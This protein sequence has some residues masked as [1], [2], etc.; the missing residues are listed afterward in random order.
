[1]DAQAQDR[2]HRIG[3]TREVH[4]KIA[5]YVWKSMCALSFGLQ[6]VFAVYRL[7]TE[8]TI[9]EN[10]LLKAKQKRNLDILVMDKGKFD[11][12][13]LFRSGDDARMA[14][15]DEPSGN[16]YSKSGLQS[17]LGMSEKDEA[18]DASDVTEKNLT[19]E[20]ME[21]AMATLEDKDDVQALRGARKEA[22]EELKEFDESVEI[23]KDAAEEEVEE[24]KTQDDKEKDEKDEREALEKEF[25][26]WQTE[27]GMDDK[28]IEASLSPIERYGLHFREDIDPYYSL[29]A[30]LEYNRKMDEAEE[31][32]NEI[33]IDEI[34]AEKAEGERQAILDGDLLVTHP[35]AEELI[36]QTNFFQRE[37][38]RLKANMKR[39]KMTGENW[40]VRE[41]QHVSKPYWYN[42][43]TGEARWDKPPVLLELESYSLANEV[44][45]AALPSLVHV[46]SFLAPYPERMKAA[47]VCRQ[48]H[49]SAMNIG[50]VRHVYPVEMGAAT[51][52]KMDHNHYRSLADAVA[53]SQPGDSVE[54]S[55]G[56]YWVNDDLV[57]DIPLRFI[58]DEFHSSNVIIEM[59]NGSCLRWRANAGYHEGITFRR[60]QI[61][62]SRV[63]SQSIIQVEEGAHLDMYQCTID[64]E[65]SG[66]RT[67]AS[68]QPHASGK[69]KKVS[70]RGGSLFLDETANLERSK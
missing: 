58:G 60:P 55:D 38:A 62:S 15:P 4:G 32:D 67:A 64:N 51:R 22:A 66:Y 30:V 27:V 49:K 13:H 69:W 16:L 19:A 47:R 7:I 52:S 44:G 50:F 3:Q 70:I 61:A 48:W 42:N 57:V 35:R 1:M 10:I 26:A 21:S 54:L 56:H 39:R 24:P 23:K 33:D 12:S 11:S 46:M 5:L 41:D 34:E 63:T 43:D 40:E 31:A 29:Y 36:R 59:N 2:A 53:V 14:A 68:I 17:I 65:G 6:Y 18:A 9:E 20:Q 8:Q 28:A 45:W 25:A 37:R